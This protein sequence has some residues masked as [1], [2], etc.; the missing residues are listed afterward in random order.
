M[1]MEI[2]NMSLSAAVLILTIVIIRRLALHRL[3]KKTFL[4]LWAVALYR[5]LIPFSVSSRFSI[6]T[7]ADMLKNRFWTA[8]TPSMDTVT[9]NTRII[10]EKLTS[11]LAEVTPVSIS[12][13]RVMWLIGL[14]ICALFFLV[15]HLRCRREYKTALPISNEFVKGWQQDH[16]IRR[17]VEIRQS[18][19]IVVPLTYGVFLP[20]ILLPKTTDWTDETKLHYILTHELVHI[21][22]FDTLTK[23]LLAAALCAHWFN[24][25][26]W[27]MY[28]LANRDIELSCDESVVRIF[29]ERMKS[30]Y[31]LT[32]IGLEEKKSRL[33]PLASN[34]NKN[35]IEERI[36]SIMK[37]KKN[38]LMGIFLAFTL[39]IGMTTIFATNAASAVDKEQKNKVYNVT[40]AKETAYI[41]TPESKAE[42]FAIYKL[43]GLTYNKS[44]DQLFYN[45]ELVR[46]FED[47]YPVGE[48]GSTGRDYFNANGTIDVHG[49][50]DL[51]Q[52]TRNPDGSTDPSGKLVGVEP[53]SQAEFDARDIDQLKNPPMSVTAV[54]NSS[55]EQ[56]ASQG[57]TST[58]VYSSEGG[59]MTPEELAKIYA[60]Y[61]PFGLIYDKKQNCFYYNGKLV[62]S[63][64]DILSS[65]GEA[66]SS[67]KF[68]G[69]MRQINNPDG[70]GEVDIKAVRDYTKPNAGGEGKLLG[71]EVVK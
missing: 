24:P 17:R 71:V 65:N 56:E 53:Y 10:T 68:K 36:V 8:N 67:G 66:L 20:V 40:I 58:I 59:M 60:V 54:E 49:V 38:S 62:R 28:V 70:K 45:G 34:F 25:L 2:L 42:A 43:Y 29:G 5:L 63:F 35:A 9:P 7:L 39:V 30:A 41:E 52:L 46:W 31:A 37:M 14:S 19:K 16:S 13:V 6:Y 18:D 12:P 55:E 50:R 3:P 44:T 47:Y 21:R 57:S 61:E 51:S 32:L 1:T 11:T 48:G 23:W 26:V 69:S 4:A 33:N 27:V 15:T 64:I 22:R